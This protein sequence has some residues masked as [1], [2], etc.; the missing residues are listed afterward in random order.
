MVRN[1]VLSDGKEL[2]KKVVRRTVVFDDGSPIKFQKVPYFS[3]PKSD[4][5]C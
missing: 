4:L 1:Y 5:K 3:M 2:S